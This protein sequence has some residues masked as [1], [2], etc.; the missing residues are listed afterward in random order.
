MR[1]SLV[2]PGWCWLILPLLVYLWWL[3]RRSYAQLL[4]AARRGALVIRGVILTLVLVAL[5]QPV[6]TRRVSGD[7]Q[8]YLL[9][10]SQSVSAENLQA[11]MADISSLAEQA[12]QANPDTRFSVVAFGSSARL[13]VA[14]EDRWPGFSDDVKDRLLYQTTLPALE[15][16]RARLIGEGRTSDD[17]ERRRLER[18][19]RDVTLFRDELAGNRTDVVVGMRL[20]LNCGP[21]S[22][23][24]SIYL[25]TDGNFNRGSWQDAWSAADTK[26][27]AI[28]IVKLDRAGEAEAAVADVMIPGKVRTNEGFTARVRIAANTQTRGELAVF[29]DGYVVQRRQV[30]LA[31]GENICEVGGLYFREKGFHSVDAV[32]RAENDTKLENNR[33][34]SIV[35]VP[36]PVRVLYVEQDDAQVSYLKSALELEGMQVDARPAGGVP[37]ELAELLSFDVFILSDVPADKLSLRQMQIIRTY[38]EDFGGGFL[39]L[40]GDQSFGLGGYYDTPIEEI[41]PVRMPIQKDLNRPSLALVMVIDKSGSMEGAKIQLAK[42]AAVAT[43]E[44]INPKDQVGLVAFDGASQVIL[45]LTSALDRTTVTSQIAA[46]DAAGGTFLYPALEDAQRLLQVSNARRKHVIVLS[47]GQ[48]EGQGYEDLVGA[49]AADGLTLSAVGIGEGA[50]MNLLESIARAGGGQAYFT[51][52]FFR[53][54][55]IFT[56]EALRASKSM[57]VE[58]LIEPAVISDDIALKEI[59]TD[60]LPLL[61]G[62]VATTA[63]DAGRTVIVSDSGDPILARWRYGLGRTAA[64]T[65]EPKPRWAEDW[66]EWTDFAKFWSQLVRSMTAGGRAAR[67]G[68]E[69]S[70]RLSGDAVVVTADVIDTAGKF[71]DDVKVESSVVDPQGHTKHVSI[72]HSGPGSFE[73]TIP[74]VEFGRPTQMIFTLAEDGDEPTPFPYAFVY[75]FSP[76]FQTMGVNAAALE[77]IGRRGRGKTMSVG[78][79][80]LQPHSAAGR[81]RLSL[82]PFLLAAALLLVPLDILCRRLG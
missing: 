33:G 7:H 73:A 62:Y 47:D 71:V 38:V 50:D 29:K 82:W 17:E 56:R 25:L 26:E 23:P 28:H 53:I 34:R 69:A 68:L 74:R 44:V 51:N 32:I 12:Q 54:P 31:K 79:V 58:K 63:K 35:V 16:E 4:P 45:E 8:V 27:M 20:A 42:R 60:Q 11:A 1:V 81:V 40:G 59:A 76:E 6:L 48:T 14:S 10:A 13:L 61:M 24:R 67:I 49:M 2:A 65:S 36:G 19:I 41:L 52:D 77:Q 78:N 70:H 39:M 57:L 72:R 66:I 22:L 80:Q 64:F 3:S 15:R 55:Q 46:L 18:R 37:S 30:E 5:S 9:D 75:P 43:A 21:R